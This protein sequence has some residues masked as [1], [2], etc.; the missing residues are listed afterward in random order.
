MGDTAVIE[1]AER[2]DRESVGEVLRTMDGALTSS[3]DP[4]V[5][6]LRRV[7]SFDSAGL[8][9]MLEGMRRARNQGVEV[10]IRGMSAPMLEFFSLVSV[11]RLLEPTVAQ[12]REPF[13]VRI[14]SAVEPLWNTVSG[15]ARI[16]ARTARDAVARPR[17]DRT[18]I[19]V[20][21]AAGGALPIVTL[22]SFLLGLVLAMQ[23]YVQLKVWGAELYMADM[24][25]VSV[26][27]EIG[28]L[29]TAII[30]A[31]RTGSSN[32]AQLGAMVIGEEIDALEQMGVR[33]IRFLVVPKV[34]ALAF[35]SVALGVVFDVV[36]MCGG[37][38]F[39]FTAAGIDPG[40]YLEQ[41]R[42]ALQVDVLP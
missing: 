3:G 29:M 1:V 35:A 17:L 36:A 31:A 4:L 41:T 8:G 13:L 20:D 18:I 22:I 40:A 12:V 24:V 10:K 23:A 2:L 27:S 28:P 9:A 39:G 37:A 30:L 32:A 42:N 33:P 25:G 21:V 7:E 34:F 26:T 6:D 19:E 38:L 11:D 14:G 5:V 15:V 16:A